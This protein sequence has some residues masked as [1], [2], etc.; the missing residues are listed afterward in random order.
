MIKGPK[1]LFTRCPGVDN[2]I[3]CDGKRSSSR[4]S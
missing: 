4:K 1:L 2:A 3:N